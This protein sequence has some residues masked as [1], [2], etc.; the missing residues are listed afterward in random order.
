MQAAAFTVETLEAGSGEVL[1]YVEDPEGHTEEVRGGPARFS[2]RCS[3][4][5]AESCF[6]FNLTGICDHVTF[7]AKVKPRKDKK[8][9]YAVTY[10]PKVEGV[11]KVRPFFFPLKK[12]YS[13]VQGYREIAKH[14]GPAHPRLPSQVKV[15]FAGQD[16]DKSP[17]TVNVAK[18]MGDPSKVHARGPGL[19]ATGNVANKPTYFDIYTAGE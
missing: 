15:L 14:F 5:P 7:Q 8:G 11:H 17:Y 10:V 3:D 6:F 4:Q 12:M 2:E 18:D 19:E 1:V 16:I 9:T 13:T